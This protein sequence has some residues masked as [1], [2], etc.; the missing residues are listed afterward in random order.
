M[1]T[2][3]EGH[4]HPKTHTHTH[5]TCSRLVKSRRRRRSGIGGVTLE[6][7]DIIHIFV[8]EGEVN[9]ADFV[10][11][12]PH[13]G[14]NSCYVIG[15]N[16]VLAKRSRA[17]KYEESYVLTWTKSSSSPSPSTTPSSTDVV[18]TRQQRLTRI[19]STAAAAKHS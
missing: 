4:M 12:R 5:A 2:L 18:H 7:W 17:A 9:R 6:T 14:E 3:L 15:R 19:Q 8:E 1:C 13:S 10:A 16:T 11:G